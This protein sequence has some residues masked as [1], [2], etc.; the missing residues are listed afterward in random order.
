MN[1]NHIAD[2]LQA[3]LDEIARLEA[4]AR[5]MLAALDLAV[6]QFDSLHRTGVLAEYQ[7]NSCTRFAREAIAQARA[8][9]IREDDR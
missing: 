3:A 9:G 5:A 6:R 1:D 7:A 2:P 8:A 4:A